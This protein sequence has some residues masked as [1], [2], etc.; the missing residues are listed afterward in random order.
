MHQKIIRH[1]Y[2]LSCLFNI[3]GNGIISAIYVT[4]LIKNG[5]NLFEV[6][7][8]NATFF[9]TLFICEIPTGAFADIFGRKTSFII[10]CGLLSVSMFIYGASH[11]FWG[12]VCA[13]ILGAISKTF[14]SGAFQAWLVD[15]L[16]HH[17]YEGAFSQIFARENLIVQIGGGLGAITGSYLAVQNFSLPWFAGGVLMVLVTI[18][19]Q[20]TMKEEYFVRTLFSWKKGLCSMRD[21]AVK[22]VQY[23]RHHKAVRFILII[24]FIQIFAVQALNMYWQPLFNSHGL[25]EINYGFVFNGMMLSLAIGAFIISRMYTKGRE[26]AIIL[27]SQVVI[28]ITVII[29][30]FATNLP[31]AITLFLLHEIGRGFWNPLK[32]SYLQERIPSSERATIT[33]FCSIAP[34]IGGAIGLLLSGFTAEYFGIPASWIMS[35]SIL[36]VGSLLMFKNGNPHSN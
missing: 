14:K 4:F 5:L 16:K 23:G 7:L 3:G 27:S 34:H 12:F 19:A 13:E 36:I 22:S 15:S 6:N 1:Y 33:S 8:V 31:I 29:M 18:T 30:A 26:K 17:G 10:A 9:F 20:L 32:D 35:G 2:I 24:T 21:I 25:A 11:T 28:G